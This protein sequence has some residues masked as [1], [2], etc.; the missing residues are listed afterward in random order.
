MSIDRTVVRHYAKLAHLEFTESEQEQLV[1]QL[2]SVLNHIEKISELDLTGVEA[3]AQVKPNADGTRSDELGSSLGTGA[4]L[5]NAPDSESGHFLVPKVIK[6][7]S[8]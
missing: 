6:V 1:K 8:Q 5:A 3:T 7:K 4:A 2:G